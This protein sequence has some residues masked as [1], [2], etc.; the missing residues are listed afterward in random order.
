M[1][2]ERWEDTEELQVQ[3]TGGKEE[4]LRQLSIS[5]IYEIVTQNA[6]LL[7]TRRTFDYSSPCPACWV[8]I[9]FPGPAAFRGRVAR[10]GHARHSFLHQRPG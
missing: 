3:S 5:T 6:R 9:Q 4:C 8:P 1:N 7:S 2:Y 10:H